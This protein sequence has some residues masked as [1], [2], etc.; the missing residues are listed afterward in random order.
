MTPLLSQIID[1]IDAAP[2]PLS[3]IDSVI[4]S[5]RRC[6]PRTVPGEA[7][8]RADHGTADLG[9]AHRPTAGAPLRACEERPCIA[10]PS[11]L[12]LHMAMS[13]FAISPKVL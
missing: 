9:A 4:R 5:A 10:A 1:A 6:A 13:F 8:E 3:P 2:S 11:F 7:A 12:L